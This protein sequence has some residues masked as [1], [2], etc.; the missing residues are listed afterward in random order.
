MKMGFCIICS[1]IPYSFLLIGGIIGTLSLLGL[2]LIKEP[3]QAESSGEN[4]ENY[5]NQQTKEE[6]PSLNAKEVLKTSLFYKVN[7]ING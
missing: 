1:R 5:E 6:L 2:L 3:K 4:C 7:K